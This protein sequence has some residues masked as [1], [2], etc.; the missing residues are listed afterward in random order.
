SG[1]RADLPRDLNEEAV[2]PG[3]LRVEA[4]LVRIVDD[5]AIDIAGDAIAVGLQ[6]GLL[7]QDQFLR[8]GDPGDALGRRQLGKAEHAL[9]ERVEGQQVALVEALGP[10]AKRR[11]AEIGERIDGRA[12]RAVTGLGFDQ[13]AIEQPGDERVDATLADV[14]EPSGRTLEETEDLIAGQRL[15]PRKETED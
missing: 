13:A 1:L 4:L 12:M 15:L 14:L 5:V 10:V 6:L 2:K 3:E 7:A 8:F 11:P 9:F